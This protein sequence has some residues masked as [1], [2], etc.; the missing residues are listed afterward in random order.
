MSRSQ[1]GYRDAYAMLL[2]A[3]LAGTPVRV[4]TAAGT[5]CG[6]YAKVTQVL[7]P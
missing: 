4:I 7:M 1:V 2:A 3:K 5:V 6:S